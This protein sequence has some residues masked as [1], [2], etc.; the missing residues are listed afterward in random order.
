MAGFSAISATSEAVLGLLQSASVGGEFDGVEFAHY[1]STDLGS[2]MTDG[3]SLYLYRITVNAN[4]NLP[5]QLRADGVRYRP[6]LPL[7]LHYLVTAWAETAPRQQR[8]LGFAIRTLEDTPILPAG[9]LNQHSP[10]PD[11]FRSHET[12][13]LV[14]E[15]VSVQDYSD[16]WDV[17]Q[18]KEQP[19]ATY[20]AR[21]VEIESDVSLDGGGLVQTRAFEYAQAESG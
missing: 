1:Q 16:I 15:S 2:P 9:V 5:P 10:E 17:A 21:M 12:V 14:F 11:V 4:R 19:S 7:D 20:V 6:P 8:M 3:L 18:T 13:E